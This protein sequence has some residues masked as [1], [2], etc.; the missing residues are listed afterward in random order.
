VDVR[1]F[2][3]ARGYVGNPEPVKS[4]LDDILFE[5]SVTSFFDEDWLRL[6]RRFSIMERGCSTDG[7]TPS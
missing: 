6:R 4:E 7:V 5:K 2:N 3:T 1:H